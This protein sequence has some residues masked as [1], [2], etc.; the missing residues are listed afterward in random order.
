MHVYPVLDPS[1]K[2]HWQANPVGT[3][4]R[5]SPTVPC[6]VGEGEALGVQP[7]PPRPS[8]RWRPLARDASGRISTSGF[9]LAQRTYRTESVSGRNPI[10]NGRAAKGGSLTPGPLSIG[11][12]ISTCREGISPW[13]LQRQ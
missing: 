12:A 13:K 10:A 5:E 3:L 8:R 2:F 11:P 4:T 1:E 7:S 6:S 9:H